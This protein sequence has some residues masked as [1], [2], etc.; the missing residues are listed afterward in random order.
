MLMKILLV[1]AILV[2]VF[3]FVVA[4][5]PSEFHITRTVTIAAPPS[6]VFEQVNDLRKW[7]AWSPWAK[8]DP[9]AK[10]TFEGPSSGAGA[11]MRWA[12]NSQ[13]GEGKMTVTESRPSSLIKMKLEFLKPFAVENAAEFTFLPQDN[14][15][16]QT[17]V[18]W[19]MS[20]K[21]NFMG[22]AMS[23]ILNCDK[24][25]GGQFEKGLA[26]LKSVVE[27]ETA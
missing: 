9:A 27:G 7:K 3:V 14:S 22:K 8:L 11:I 2:T 1:L 10:E 18:T 17:V 16:H 20:G 13:V 4:T 23:L 21:S 12:G 5:R 19:S 24:M 26:Q 25:V 15:S 6:A